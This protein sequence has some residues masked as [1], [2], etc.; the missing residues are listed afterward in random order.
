MFKVKNKTIPC[1]FQEKFMEVNH[2]YPT[3]FSQNN[4]YQGNIKLSQ[5]KFA[6]SSRGPRLWNNILTHA[7]KQ[8]TSK[9]SFK[10]SIK[11]TLLKLC[12]VY[13]YF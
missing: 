11:E 4:Y 1:V 12:N 9:C 10:K 5:T 6:I 3:R 13:D 8:C 2:Q 7:Q